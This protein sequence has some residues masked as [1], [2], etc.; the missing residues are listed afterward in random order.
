MLILT[1]R[2]PGDYKQSFCLTPEKTATTR[3]ITTLMMIQYYLPIA[4]LVRGHHTHAGVVCPDCIIQE[5]ILYRGRIATV[6]IVYRDRIAAVRIVCHD[7]ITQ[8]H[9]CLPCAHRK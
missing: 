6:S 2:T 4:Y 9:N 5:D 3:L 7:R 1:P 8:I